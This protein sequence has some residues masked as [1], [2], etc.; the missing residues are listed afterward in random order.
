MKV[1]TVADGA[2]IAVKTLYRYFP[3][4]PHVLVAVLAR[5]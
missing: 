3:S 5:A 4:K 2:G 1:R